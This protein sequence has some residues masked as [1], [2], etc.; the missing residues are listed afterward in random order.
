MTADN[1]RFK[2]VFGGL[3]HFESAFTFTKEVLRDDPR[4]NVVRCN[5]E[6][7]ETEIVDADIVIPFMVPI[8]KHLFSLA[9]KLKMV[10]TYKAQKHLNL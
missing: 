2:I 6:A 3:G 5:T 8:T 7:M 1:S 9:P 10:R 4:I